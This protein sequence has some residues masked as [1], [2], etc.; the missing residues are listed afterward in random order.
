MK[1]FIPI[2]DNELKKLLR[3]S[4]LAVSCPT[5]TRL[6]SSVHLSKFAWWSWN[7]MLYFF[8][9]GTGKKC[10]RTFGLFW[11]RSLPLFIWTRY[12]V[13]YKT[14]SSSFWQ[15]IESPYLF[16]FLI[17]WSMLVQ[18]LEPFWV[19]QGRLRKHRKRTLSKRS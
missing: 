19:L 8:V 18:L 6:Q 7:S 17:W 15:C 10:W 4:L 3:L 11:W 9:D 14:T 16:F 1:E 13:E 5:S 2:A 12:V